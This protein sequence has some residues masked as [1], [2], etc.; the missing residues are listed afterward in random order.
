MLSKM[1]SEKH[2]KELHIINKLKYPIVFL[3]TQ[4]FIHGQ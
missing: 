1:N 4:L 2:N 3:A